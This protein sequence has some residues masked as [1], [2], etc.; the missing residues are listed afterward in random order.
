MR[1]RVQSL[2][3]IKCKEYYKI[4]ITSNIK[5]RIYTL[6]SSNPYKLK[7]IFLK[8]FR[9]RKT[10]RLNEVKLHH[11]FHDKRGMGEWFKLNSDD[12]KYIKNFKFIKPL[13]DNA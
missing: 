8:K 13:K 12:V 4:G 1:E 6:Q 7:I 3:A 10:V 9:T 11:H 5:D 2:Y